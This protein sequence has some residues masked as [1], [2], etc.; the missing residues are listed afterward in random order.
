M[1]HLFISAPFGEFKSTLLKEI[2]QAYPSKIYTHLT[3]PSLIGSIDKHTKQIIP[4]A[5]WECRNKLM[6]LDEFIATRPSLVSQTL[7]QL[8]EDQYYSRKIAVYSADLN[9]EDGDLFF[10][11]KQGSIEVKTRFLCIMATMKNIKKAREYAFKALLSRY[12]LALILLFI[13]SDLDASVI[14]ISTSQKFSLV[15]LVSSSISSRK[16][17]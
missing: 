16:I 12:S 4:A 14:A 3:F 2:N 9:E 15:I 13:A 17:R 11:V 10:R 5:A 1:L 8:L 7:L 6:L